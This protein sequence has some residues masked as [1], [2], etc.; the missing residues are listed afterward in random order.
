MKIILFIIVIF[1]IGIIYFYIKN[2]KE[3]FEVRGNK[4]PRANKEIYDYNLEQ[5][6]QIWTEAGCSN[7]KYKPNRRNKRIWAHE[8]W[9]KEV[10]SYVKE[11][12]KFDKEHNWYDYVPGRGTNVYIK[13]RDVTNEKISPIGIREAWKRCYGDDLGPYKF[14]K[15]GDI[16]RLKR[17]DTSPT[18]EYYKGVVISYSSWRGPRV[19]WTHKG[20]PG[21]GKDKKRFKTRG[22]PSIVSDSRVVQTGKEFGWPWWSWNRGDK[23]S[24]YMTPSNWLRKTYGGMKNNK[25]G[26]YSKKRLYKVSECKKKGTTGCDYLRCDKR[27]EAVLNDYPLTYNCSGDPRNKHKGVWMCGRGSK[28]GKFYSYYDKN[29]MCRDDYKRGKTDTFC[30]QECGRSCIKTTVNKELKRQMARGTK[31][32]ILASDNRWSARRGNY[33]IVDNSTAFIPK[34]KGFYNG[35]CYRDRRRRD[36]P[37]Y[38]GRVSNTK[39]C[40]KKAE[41]YGMPYAGLQY[42]GQCFA[43]WK[44]GSYGSARNCNMRRGREILGGSWANNVY[45]TKIGKYIPKSIFKNGIIRSIQLYGRSCKFGGGKYAKR[46]GL[47]RNL[48]MKGFNTS[49]AY[50][51]AKVK[52]GYLGCNRFYQSYDDCKR[53]CRGRGHMSC[54]GH[55]MKLDTGGNGCNMVPYDLIIND[56][57]KMWSKKGYKKWENYRDTRRGAVN[58]ALIKYGAKPERNG[59]V[60]RKGVEKWIRKS[61]YNRRPSFRDVIYLIKGKMPNKRW[62]DWRYRKSFGYN[63]ARK[64]TGSSWRARRQRRGSDGIINKIYWPAH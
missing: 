45:R 46:P 39:S 27:K 50:N 49:C 41:K 13:R 53:R 24:D 37:L 34:I 2:R 6:L 25:F 30:K 22:L 40:I 59:R 11:A 64:S 21:G 8:N 55:T 12:K 15:I 17:N 62:R 61:K 47:H 23:R 10:E 31:C 63:W 18:S 33:A 35:K 43:G 5:A 42:R 44:P 48:R 58:K 7:G 56:Q 38:L 28:K 14:P 54:R 29:T 9:R 36:L 60:S 51:Q 57:R 3:N 26:N 20:R 52:R 32:G 19:M 16:V 1:I 4:Q